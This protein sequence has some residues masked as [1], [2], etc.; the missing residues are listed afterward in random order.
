M[1][2]RLKEVITEYSLRKGKNWKA[3]LA[4]TLGKS[5]RTILRWTTDGVPSAHEA[6]DL[7]LACGCREKEALEIARE[8]SSRAEKSA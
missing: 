4:T 2:Q 7:A 5:E 3:E 1:S 6:R 8:F